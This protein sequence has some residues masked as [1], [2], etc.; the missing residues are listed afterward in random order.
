M[1]EP[2]PITDDEIDCRLRDALRAAY[3]PVLEEPVPAALHGALSRRLKRRRL[4][5]L[6]AALLAS[7]AA[8]GLWTGWQLQDAGP[9]VNAQ[10]ARRAAAAHATYAAEVRHPVEVGADQEAQLAAWL[11]ERLGMKVWAPDLQGTGMALVGGR[12]LPG[13]TRPAALL[14]YEARDGRRVTIYWS[15]D[16]TRKGDSGLGYTRE[17]NL[18]IFHWVDEECGYAVASADTG[19]EALRRIASLVYEQLEK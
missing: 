14:M 1:N 3:D 15:P 10:V 4:G 19:K 7:G 6:V 12:L 18:D 11:S 8:I 5:R 2:P 13:E 17:K 16:T 9:D